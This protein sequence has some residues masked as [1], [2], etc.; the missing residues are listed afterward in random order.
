MEDIK[1]VIAKNIADLRRRDGLTQLDLAE[2]LNYT[3]KAVSKWERG[4]SVPDIAVLKQIAD[5]FHVTVDY[6]VTEEHDSVSGT[7]QSHSRKKQ[8]R[9]FITGMSV[10]LVWLIATVAFCAS[11]RMRAYLM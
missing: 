3:D 10:L 6:L 1:Q 2:H 9:A 7:K 4:E 8:N 5:L 11:G